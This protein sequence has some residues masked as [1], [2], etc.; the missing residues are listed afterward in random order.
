MNEWVVF[1][2]CRPPN[3]SLGPSWITSLWSYAWKW[4]LATCSL[5]FCSL[6]LFTICSRIWWYYPPLTNHLQIDP[7]GYG[8]EKGERSARSH[9]QRLPLFIRL[10]DF[11][12]TFN[13]PLSLPPLILNSNVF[14]V[15]WYSFSSVLESLTLRVTPKPDYIPNW[16]LLEQA[17]TQPKL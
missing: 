2:L 7:D 14:L 13:S 11:P 4:S 12:T 9:L 6:D 10:S 16:S 3:L 1:G 5:A 15:S 17:E 8:E